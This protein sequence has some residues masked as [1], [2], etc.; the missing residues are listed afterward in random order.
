MRKTLRALLS[1]G[2]VALAAPAVLSAQDPETDAVPAAEAAPQPIAAEAVLEAVD[3][4]RAAIRA[5]EARAEL[6]AD[7][8]EVVIVDE[9]FPGEHATVLD[10]ALA[11]DPEAQMELHAAIAANEAIGAVLVEQAIS[12][13]DVVALSLPESGGAVVYAR[14]PIDDPMD[15]IDDGSIDDGTTDGEAT[16]G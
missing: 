4:A 12:P 7:E 10:E 15:P 5:L 1:L 6:T 3:G 8:V 11:K 2:V 13:D 9:L 16:D 14:Q